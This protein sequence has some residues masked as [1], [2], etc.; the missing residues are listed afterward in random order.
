MR[1]LGIDYGERRVGLALS[2]PTGTVATPLPPLLRRRGKRPP[3]QAI[4]DVINANDVTRVVVGL[5]LSLEGEDTDWTREVRA[6]ASR[7]AARSG[8]DVFLIDERLSSV[9]ATHAVRSIGLS[10]QEREKKERVD[11]AAAVLLLQLFLDRERSGVPLERAA[12][13]SNGDA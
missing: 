3:V 4:V 2:D 9:M 6:F 5:P 8:R 12:P 7:V 1:A 13:E 11:T 10:R